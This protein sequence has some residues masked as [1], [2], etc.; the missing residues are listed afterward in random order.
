MASAQV[1]LGTTNVNASI[2]CCN[3]GLV[4][5]SCFSMFSRNAVI[6]LVGLVM[7]VCTLRNPYTFSMKSVSSDLASEDRR[8]ESIFALFSYYTTDSGYIPGTGEG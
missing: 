3:S 8:R 6:S 5:L 2:S 7:A 1:M 4:G